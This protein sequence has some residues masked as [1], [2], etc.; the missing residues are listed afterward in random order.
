MVGHDLRNPLQVIINTLYLARLKLKQ[1]PPQLDK[2][3][4]EEIYSKIES[5]V[6]YMD[7]IVTDLQDFSRPITLKPF[8]T[9]LKELIENVLSSISVPENVKVSLTSNQKKPVIRIDPSSIKRVF[10]NLILN[11]LQAM[12]D[13]GNLTL[14]INLT[15]E[16]AAI[17]VED[18]GVGISEESKSRIFEP[19][20]TTKAQGQGLGLSICK[21]FVEAN[22][23]SIEVQSEEGKGTIFKVTLPIV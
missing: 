10:Y 15:D 13:G 12:P 16:N 5:Q 2:E 17:T 4:I 20:F 9:D 14:T 23:G 21:K 18:T 1:I 3:E 8:K 22:S 11:A 19:F 7:K 6:L